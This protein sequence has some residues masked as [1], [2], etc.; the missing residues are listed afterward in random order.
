MMDLDTVLCFTDD[1]GCAVKARPTVWHPE[2]ALVFGQQVAWP[3]EPGAVVYAALPSGSRRLVF[4]GTS[5]PAP[6]AAEA[7][8]KKRAPRKRAARKK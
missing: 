5:Q 2:W 6:P 1:N 8:A 7:S 3:L 4:N